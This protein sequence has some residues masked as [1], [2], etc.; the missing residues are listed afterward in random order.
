MPEPVA[1]PVAL[2]APPA[3]AARSSRPRWVAF[4][5]IAAAL[6]LAVGLGFGAAR[7]TAPSNDAAHRQIAVLQETTEA[8]LRLEAQSDTRR[9]ALAATPAGGAAQGTLLFSPTTGELVMV[10]SGL[11]DLAPGQEYGCWVE[12]NGKR[13]RIGRMYP[14][15]DLQ[16]W[17][18]PVSGLAD[19][20]ADAVFGVSLVPAGGGAGE[21]Q[22]TGG[23]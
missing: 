19:L 16:S 1:I 17:A 23:L 13:T 3:I 20:P 22:L 10:A 5:G 11:A 21:P 9:I 8:T 15:G 18:G 6:V 2:P 7:V 4:A 12:V 14:G